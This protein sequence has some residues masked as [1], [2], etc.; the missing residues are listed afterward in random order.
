MT[1]RG[2]LSKAEIYYIQSNP[3]ELSIEELSKEMDRSMG[4]IKKFMDD[5]KKATQEENE[6]PLNERLKQARPKKR[7]ESFAQQLMGQVKN[8]DKQVG[9]VMTPAASEYADGTRKSRKM[10]KEVQEAVTK[11]YDD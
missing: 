10:K 1:K 11:I 5:A 2:P 8:K 3:E 6:K 7:K 9:V 4:Q